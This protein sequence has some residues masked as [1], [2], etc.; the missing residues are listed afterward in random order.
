MSDLP[1]KPIICMFLKP[2]STW[3]PQD[4]N[5]GAVWNANRDEFEHRV[6]EFVLGVL[7]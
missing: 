4:G 1:K 3:F 7:K 6:R 2:A 5:H